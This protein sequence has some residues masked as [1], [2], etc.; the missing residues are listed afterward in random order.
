MN[1]TTAVQKAVIF[2][3]RMTLSSRN[4]GTPSRGGTTPALADEIAFR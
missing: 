1:H 4:P 2:K 3:C